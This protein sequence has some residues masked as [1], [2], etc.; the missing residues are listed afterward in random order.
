MGCWNF[1]LLLQARKS[2]NKKSFNLIR[3][4]LK[5]II[6]ELFIPSTEYFTNTV[7]LDKKWIL[8]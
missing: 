3:L 7:S 4:H 8:L 2:L 5:K 6:L 1:S